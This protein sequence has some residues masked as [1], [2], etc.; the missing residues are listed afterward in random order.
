MSPANNDQTGDPAGGVVVHGDVVH[1]DKIGRDQITI[2]GSTGVAIGRN[3]QAREIVSHNS[4]GLFAPVYEHIDR[5]RED[6]DIDRVELLQIVH[7][8]EDEVA[9]G[10]AANPTKL[11]RWL[12]SLAAISRDVFD[13]VLATLTAPVSGVATAIRKIAERVQRE[14]DVK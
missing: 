11:A 13:V 12:R 10:D 5:R 4:A 6:P 2:S 7:A 9:K 14:F 1:G 8:L 3:A